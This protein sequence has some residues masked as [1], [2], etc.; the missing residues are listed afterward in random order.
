MTKVGKR[1]KEVAAA[2]KPFLSG[3]LLS[4]HCWWANSACQ[5]IRV[6]YNHLVLLYGQSFFPIMKRIDNAMMDE[7]FFNTWVL[8]LPQPG[9]Q[10]IKQ[11]N[12]IVIV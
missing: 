2:A 7:Y 11:M 1:V 6:N 10:I 3:P 12:S 9:K 5:I 4:L 8:A